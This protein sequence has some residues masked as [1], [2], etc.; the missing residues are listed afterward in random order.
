[1]SAPVAVPANP[2]KLGLILRIGLFVLLGYL[3][4]IA[5]ALVLGSL[6]GRF[7]T[8]TLSTFGA[9]SVANAVTVRI[10]ERGS[11]ADLGLAWRPTSAREFLIGAGAGIV[12]ATLV[13]GGPVVFHA[14]HFVGAPG[15]EHPI[16]AFF[17][18][19]LLLLFGAL[20]EEMS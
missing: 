2:D 5:F 20:G 9:A 18:V 19:S 8:A 10:F 11:L 1:M 3:G 7:I 17:F 4:L 12:A 13:L 16:G 14:A 6:G 15:V